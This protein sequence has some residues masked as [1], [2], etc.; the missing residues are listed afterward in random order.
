MQLKLQVSQKQTQEGIF[1][2]LKPKKY[3]HL[4][5]TELKS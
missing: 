2:V 5:Q 1:L 3:R 4:L